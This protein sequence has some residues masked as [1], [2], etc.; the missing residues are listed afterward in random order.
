MLKKSSK[1]NGN[2]G[3]TP[4]NSSSNNRV[5][6][7]RPP[8]ILRRASQNQTANNGAN[9]AMMLLPKVPPTAVLFDNMSM[10]L[11]QLDS[12]CKSIE[13]SL[14]KSFSQKIADW[15]LQ[16]WSPG[17]ETALANVTAGMREQLRGVNRE[18]GVGVPSKSGGKKARRLPLLNPVDSGE[19]LAS[20]DP[21][22]SYILPSAHFPLL[23][24]FNMHKCRELPPFLGRA[25][26]ADET[27]GGTGWMAESGESGRCTQGEEKLYRTRV[28]VAALRGGSFL[29]DDQAEVDSNTAGKKNAGAGAGAA[30]A[31]AA[32]ATALESA[33]VVHCAIAG[34]VQETDR[35]KLEPYY[36]STTHRWHR[37]N[38]LTYDTRSRWGHP[39]TISLRL[40]SLPSA[41][42]GD[43]G[44]SDNQSTKTNNDDGRK[45]SQSPSEVGYCWV[46]L[47]PI[48]AKVPTAKSLSRGQRNGGGG[49][50]ISSPVNRATVTCHTRVLSFDGTE[51]FDQHGQVVRGPDPVPQRLELELKVTTEVIP[52]ERTR[53]QRKRLLLYK[54]DDDLRQ[55]MLAIQFIETC[56]QLLRASGL[57]LKLLT[58]RCIAVGA[59]KGFIEW[60]TGSV[61][62]S[63]ICQG[64][65]SFLGGGSGGLGGGSSRNASEVSASSAG[66]G[67]GQVSAGSGVGN[68][69]QA[70]ESSDGGGNT[71]SKFGRQSSLEAKL[72]EKNPLGAYTN[73]PGGWCKYQSLRSVRQRSRS[74]GGGGVIGPT[75]SSLSLSSK[76]NNNPIQDFLRSAAYDANAPY[77]IRREVMDAYVK[78]CAGYCVITYLLGV[79]DRHLDNL[80]LHPN[81][82]FLHC[83]YSFILGQD[84]KTYLPMRITED[85]VLGMGGRDSD[86]FAMFLSLAGAA[87]VAFRRHDN[88]R[89]LMSL[90]RLMTSSNLPDVSKNQT[91]EDA[92]LA[93]RYRFRL[94]L[95]DD[96]AIT[97]MERLIETSIASKLWIAVDAIH[98]LGKRF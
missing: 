39:K 9:A 17:K 41:N 48:W 22:E 4:S 47:S 42:D 56:D 50:E 92:L 8:S 57:D 36:E 53:H 37:G 93:M 71:A 63:E 68:G 60:V 2:G 5:K 19:L 35:S 34:V 21:D 78:S 24:C 87:F 20:V 89:T 58:F 95:T 81:G 45:G 33:Y 54:H 40:S 88:V 66:G 67:G 65:S 73:R 72:E 80:L 38:V 12:I 91:T 49:T 77:F 44:G 7:N 76:N 82:H 84:P 29:S 70:A 69:G 6:A 15:A 79:G 97:F 64:S 90:V 83:D 28:E 43:G 16:P 61:P 10:F 26:S 3:G 52:L 46:D 86:N 13:R 62:L 27:G 32:A 74:G 25:N 18:A 98:S 14:L 31:G 30:T 23:L 55:E 96:G 75:G 51:E 1:R 59:R 11:N 85:M 94:D